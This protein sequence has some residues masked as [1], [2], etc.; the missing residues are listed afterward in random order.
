MMAREAGALRLGYAA[1]VQAMRVA[2]AQHRLLVAVGQ[3]GQR[4][5]AAQLGG[6]LH[7]D[8]GI[9]D[10]DH[11]QGL[12]NRLARHA[13]ADD[14]WFHSHLCLGRQPIRF[15]RPRSARIAPRGCGWLQAPLGAR[16]VHG[17]RGHL[18]VGDAV[19]VAQRLA[20]FEIDQEA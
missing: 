6:R 14:E 20:R 19:A 4:L 17:Q 1:G 9:D 11:G 12:G 5:P 7:G 3:S 2:N 13:A 16:L 8:V 10:V 18:A 15:A